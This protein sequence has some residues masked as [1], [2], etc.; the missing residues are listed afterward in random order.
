M[1][2]AIGP[3]MRD[4]VSLGNCRIAVLNSAEDNLK[5]HIFSHS[6]RFLFKN[7]VFNDVGDKSYRQ[8]R[9]LIRH[10]DECNTFQPAN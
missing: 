9:H 6:A 1:F 7:I 2:S 4:L 8:V 5:N 3:L 10:F